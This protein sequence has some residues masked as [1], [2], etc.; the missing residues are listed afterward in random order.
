MDELQVKFKLTLQDPLAYLAARRG[1]KTQA[2]KTAPLGSLVMP[3]IELASALAL[4]S[5]SIG[6]R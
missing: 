1:R 2:R 6:I 3:D 4:H 5:A